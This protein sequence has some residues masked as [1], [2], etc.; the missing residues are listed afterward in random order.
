MSEDTNRAD[1]NPPPV[2]RLSFLWRRVNDHKIVQWTVGYVAL[3]YAIQ[4][5]VILTSESFEWPNAVA[6][7][8]MLLLALGLPLVATLAWYHGERASR[9]ISGPELSIISILLVIGSLFFYVFVRPSADIAAAPAPAVQQAGVT[10]ARNASLN[11]ATA[12]SIAVL[13]FANVSADAD[14]EFFSDGMTDEISGALAKIPDLRVVGRS[15]AFQ[16]KKHDTDLRAIGKALG[17]THLI[18]GSVRKAGNRVR[19][20]AQLVQSDNGLQVWSE[21]YDRDLTDVFAIQDDIAK[22]I[23]VSLRMPLSLKPGENLV[24]NRGV[25]PEFYQQFLRVRAVA[26]GRGFGANGAPAIEDLIARNPNYAPA[27]GLLALRLANV[28]AFERTPLYTQPIEEIRLQVQLRLEKAE[29]AAREAIRLDPAQAIAYA[30]LA[31]IQGQRK[32][33]AGA[34]DI[35]RQALA[36]DPGEPELLQRYSEMLA[37]TG[38]LKESLRVRQQL[39]TLEPFVPIYNTVTAE[40]MQ[41]NGQNEESI[42][43]LDPIPQEIPNRDEMLARAYAVTGRYGQAADTLL[44]I[45]TQVSRKSVED[46]ARLLRAGPAKAKGRES[47]PVLEERLNFVYAIAG[48]PD[49]VLEHPERALDAGMA[50]GGAL[51]M[52]WHSLNAPVRKTE[53]FKALMRKAGLVDYW[54]ARGWPDL[55]HPVGGD[56]FACD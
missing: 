56:D 24:N 51:R 27:W 13:P 47:L 22:A 3:A 1:A 2:D 16:Y 42:R 37:H 30:Q 38:R 11:P 45:K 34:E 43:L 26:R 5:A 29:M 55:C 14:Q 40:I 18:E 31:F 28:I 19:I 4:H 48:A 32:N 20:T 39:Q 12:I 10:A 23:A 35:F 50:N 15:S 7:V 49:R 53:R 54:R 8:S 17:A 25:D 6:R 33:W 46:A 41:L 9:R 21:N 36:L 44:L 52:V